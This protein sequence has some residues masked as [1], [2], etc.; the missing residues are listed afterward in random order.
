M[1]FKQY[2]YVSCIENS[3]L[4]IQIYPQPAQSFLAQTGTISLLTVI[5]PATSTIK[6]E[7]KLIQLS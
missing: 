1:L 5:R 2:K 4:G 3:T 6:S 7:P